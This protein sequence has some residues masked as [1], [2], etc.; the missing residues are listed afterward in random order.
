MC[1]RRGDL[2]GALC[3]CLA[4]DIGEVHDVLR[5]LRHEPLEVDAAGLDRPVAGD[6]G[7]D[8]VQRRG[9]ANVDPGHDRGLR[10]VRRRNDHSRASGCSRRDGHRERAANRTQVPFEADLAKHDLP[11]QAIRG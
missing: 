9:A 5:A 7:T 11:L 3:G 6:P 1:P 8:F 2:Q 10:Q 4:P